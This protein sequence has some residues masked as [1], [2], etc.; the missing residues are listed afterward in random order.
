M[1]V[2]GD[3]RQREDLRLDVGLEVEHDANHPRPVVRDA[4]A[5]DV[6]IFGRYLAAE[7]GECRGQ[8]AG[9]QIEYQPLWI[10][11]AEKGELDAGSGLQGEARVFG[12]GPDA[13]RMDLRLRAS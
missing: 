4:Q 8:F 5:P 1:A 11:E 3:G 12:R 7:L 2:F 6:R 9:F 10:L 13:A